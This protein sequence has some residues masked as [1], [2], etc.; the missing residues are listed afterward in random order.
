MSEM[1]TVM[2]RDK[3][4]A[5]NILEEGFR[6]LNDNM[7]KPPYGAFT[8]ASMTRPSVEGYIKPSLISTIA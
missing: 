7:I 3:N 6:I 5:I 4:A 8:R 2:D 1:W